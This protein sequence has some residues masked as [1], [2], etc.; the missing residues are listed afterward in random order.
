MLF[1]GSSSIRLWSTLSQD[2]APLPVINRGFGGSHIEYVNRWFEPL[3]AAY[4]PSVIVFYA[5]ENDIDAGKPVQRV[6]ADFAAFMK[7]EVA[8]LGE[9]PVYFISLKPSKLRAAQLGLQREVNAA[10][11][12][13]AGERG[14]LHFIDVATAM[15]ED[16]RP[17]DLFAA[18]NLHMTRAGYA[19]WT[20]QLRAA[21]LPH[22]QSDASR[23]IRPAAANR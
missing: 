15:L 4:R 5:G 2:M 17:R 13:L 16:G 3:V 1:V 7:L 23:C 10:V 8:A 9:V 21:L 14:D 11:R 18:D 6:L 12:A 22:A 20:R 19:I